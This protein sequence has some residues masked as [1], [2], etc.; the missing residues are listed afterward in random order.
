MVVEDID[1][2]LPFYTGVL[3]LELVSDIAVPAAK[4]VATGLAPGGY[5]IVRLETNLG[6]RLK[7]VRPLTAP[8]RM[9]AREYAL[10]Q[11]N[12]TYV[13][14]VVDSLADVQ[15]RLAQSTAT[16][17]STGIVEVRT[18]VRLVLITDPAGNFLE[19]VQYDDIEAHRPKRAAGAT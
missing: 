5:R 7:L 2:L 18:G 6:D 10:S 17:L 19:F 3:G 14:F 4:S 13:T 15:S 11:E 12:G 9:A 16:L 8:V 1:A